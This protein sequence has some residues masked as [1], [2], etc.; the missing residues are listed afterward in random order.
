MSEIERKDG[1]EDIVVDDCAKRYRIVNKFGKELGIITINPADMNITKR[2]EQVVQ[3]FNGLADDIGDA[4][5]TP[6]LDE[7]E[8]KLCNQ[9]DY[10]LA[11]AVSETLF[12]VT[13][14]FSMTKS[15]EF[16]AENVLNAIAAVIEKEI[17]IR[18]R[19]AKS[20]IDR[21]TK[22]YSK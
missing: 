15:G 19:K 11:D 5:G 7:A 3:V 8:E 6:S 9:I 14:P 21:Y 18:V 16:F 22:K 12:K 13:S 10:L 1:I 4:E 2:Y 20:R 17:G